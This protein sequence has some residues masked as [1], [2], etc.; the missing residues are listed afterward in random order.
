VP[1]QRARPSAKGVG[2]FSALG[3]PA[4]VLMAPLVG[5]VELVGGL[6]F[7][8]GWCTRLA[9]IPLLLDLVVA[10][11]ATVILHTSLAE[12][13]FECLWLDYAL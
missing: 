12:T 6:L 5:G 11:L 1:T 3:I 10:I 2:R 4:P 7:L 13:F 8:L 9:A